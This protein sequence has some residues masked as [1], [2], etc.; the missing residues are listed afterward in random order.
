M[1]DF[2]LDYP[3]SKILNNLFDIC[4]EHKV[5]CECVN[6]NMLER[7]ALTIIRQEST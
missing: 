5:R 1:I 7:L 4:Q 2:D 6:C 3:L